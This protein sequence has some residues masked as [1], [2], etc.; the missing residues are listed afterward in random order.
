MLPESK[1]KI[2]RA[3]EQI[4]NL[5]SELNA[6]LKTKPYGVL[7]YYDVQAGERVD[8]FRVN[9]VAPLRFAVIV[10]E[11]LH[12]LRSSLDQVICH[13][14]RTNAGDTA[15]TKDSGFPF[16]NTANGFPSV[17]GGKVKGARAEVME[18]VRQIEPYPGGN[19]NGIWRLHQANVEEKHKLSVIV[20]CACRSYSYNP[21][22]GIRT[23]ASQHLPPMRWII[24]GVPR[25]TVEDG[26]ELRRVKSAFDAEFNDEDEFT[27]EIAFSQ[28][29]ILE[30]E[31][32][33]PTLT[34]F[35]GLTKS[36]LKLFDGLL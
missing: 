4:H 10:G 33:I 17:L 15:I 1:A 26:A 11:I 30:G 25:I 13:L 7:R 31:A 24:T 28:P 14:I 12:D 32:L 35:V 34:Q 16:S 23:G 29:K 9:A 3:E 5:E 20:G 21:W 2:E 18:M 8:R 27:F 22:A 19:G 6:F 36:T